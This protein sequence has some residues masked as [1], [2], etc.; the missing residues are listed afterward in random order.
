MYSGIFPPD[1]ELPL[2]IKNDSPLS[3]P[4]VFPYHPP[5]PTHSSCPGPSV[6][7]HRSSIMHEITQE[8]LDHLPDPIAKLVWEKWI[9]EGKARLV[10]YCEVK[11]CRAAT[12]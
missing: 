10:P 11:A 2:D 7:A 12:E 9:A 1:H 8:T 5:S 4:A 6:P 3:P